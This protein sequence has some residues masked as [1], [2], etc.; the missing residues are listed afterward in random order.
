MFKNKLVVKNK[1]FLGS[2]DR[3]KLISNIKSALNVENEEE[4]EE[5]LN[6]DDTVICK[7]PNTKNTL[8]ISKE[9]PVF[10][11]VNNTI[12]PTI[13]TLW[14]LPNLI[15]CFVI[16]P[17]ASE[18]LLRGA[19]LMIPGI[20]TEIQQAEKLKVGSVWGVRVFNN[21]HIFAVGQCLV[22]CTNAKQFNKLKGRCLK[23]LHVF[24]DELWKLGKQN[25]PDKSFKHNVID[26]VEQI[27]D[28]F[29]GFKIYEETETQKQINTREKQEGTTKAETKHKND[30]GEKKAEKKQTDYFGWGSDEE[31]EEEDE[32]NK[33]E[34]EEE[35]EEEQSAE[36]SKK[37]TT[38]KNV[39]NIRPTEKH[40]E[41][42]YKHL[43]VIRKKIENKNLREI[44]TNDVSEEVIIRNGEEHK[45]KIKESKTKNRKEE[46]REPMELNTAFDEMEKKTHLSEGDEK[47]NHEIIHKEKG[48]CM[49]SPTL[50]KN[51]KGDLVDTMEKRQ[52]ANQ[53]IGLDKNENSEDRAE[54]NTNDTQDGPN[55]VGNVNH[56]KQELQDALKNEQ[57]KEQ[58]KEQEREPKDGKGKEENLR[59]RKATFVFT[60]PQHDTLLLYLLLEVLHTLSDNQL[61]MEFSGVYSRMNT[62]CSY[63]HKNEMFLDKLNESNVSREDIKR[64]KNN[65]IK[66]M[67][68]IKKSTFKKLGKF[69]QHC[70]KLKL[71][72][73]KEN[74]SGL[75][76]INICRENPVFRSYKPLHMDVKK[77]ID[78]DNKKE[79]E[80]EMTNEKNHA[81]DGEKENERA[82]EKD[83]EKE[84]EKEGIKNETLNK[85]TQVLE[86]YM[87]TTKT[88]PIFRH[89]DLKT[90][91]SSY[92]NITQLKDI[93][94]KFVASEK[95]QNEKNAS[96]VTINETL[97]TALG[98]EN[99]RK[100]LPY[101]QVLKTFL[102][103]QQPC[104][105]IIKPF[106]N[107]EIEPIKVIKGTCPSIHI[108]AVARMGGSKWVTHVTNLS[109]FYLDLNKVSDNLQKQLACS[110]TVAVSPSTK[111]EEL[112]VQG[113][114]VN[115]ISQ[116]LITQ[117]Y[118][119]KKYIALNTKGV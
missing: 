60:A 89:I 43:E 113:N 6:K 73:V 86:F 41:V 94:K 5:L 32:E 78:T 67:A 85:G 35:E 8:Y 30:K 87:P 96:L 63:I 37:K 109:L 16:Y 51:D 72:K 77:Q 27:I 102:S 2:K 117:Y 22:D 59:G 46:K 69:T 38:D 7:V 61:P 62:E 97:Q 28:D 13:Y 101:E 11:C 104:Y 76:L 112:L 64:I 95:L 9:V 118:L 83:R 39:K 12:V 81:A 3:K 114:A 21:P 93:F 82:K 49:Y 66:L 84:R 53:E 80:N 98:I 54:K 100:E 48:K 92:F 111:K 55:G 88:L 40:L 25:I 103:L 24:H 68:D 26:S 65:E 110:C 57:E 17:P 45:D 47:C 34:G 15:P 23:L 19:D 56:S 50:K 79:R 58:E 52:A 106:T 18:Y 36:N 33:E 44:E 42:F 14:K 31:D 115:K 29:D 71:I 4:L 74:R 107:F 20:C 90:T 105:S 1:N 119:P 91:K 99:N 75:Y 108:Y 70:V 116:I 10:F